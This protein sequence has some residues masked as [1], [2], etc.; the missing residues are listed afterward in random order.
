MLLINVKRTR[1]IPSQSPPAHRAPQV[2][3]LSKHPSKHRSSAVPRHSS[4][5]IYPGTHRDHDNTVSCPANMPGHPVSF[6]MLNDPCHN[7]RMLPPLICSIYNRV[8]LTGTCYPCGGIYS[9]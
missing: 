4:L 3:H 9:G 8:G 1:C 5:A 2:V 7:A 6:G